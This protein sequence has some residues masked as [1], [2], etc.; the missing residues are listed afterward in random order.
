MMRL[1]P[2]LLL[3]VA[4]RGDDPDVLLVNIISTPL[5]AETSQNAEPSL[6][7]SPKAPNFLVASVW[8]PGLSYCAADSAV[9]FWTADEGQ[10]WTPACVLPKLGDTE[11]QDVTVRMSGDAKTL[12]ASWM[13]SQTTGTTTSY[14]A[15][16]YRFAPASG[17]IDALFPPSPSLVA[18]GKQ[19]YQRFDT[20]QP[21][22]ANP[23]DAIA[24]LWIGNHRADLPG[25]D[26][27][28]YVSATFA[29]NPVAGPS[30]VNC[31][32]WDRPPA[33]SVPPTPGRVSAARAAMVGGRTYV[34]IYRMAKNGYYDVVVYR[35]DGGDF[36]V[37]T[38]SVH[39]Q[40]GGGDCKKGRDALPGFRVRRCA[41][42]PYLFN[43]AG[44]PGQES[45]HVSELSIA[46]DPTNPDKVYVAW[47][48]SS[49]SSEPLKLQFARSTDGGR[50]WTLIENLSTNWYLDQSTNPALAVNSDGVVGI[51]YQQLVKIKKA[52][53][54]Q[55]Q[56]ALS[57]D[58]LAT[59]PTPI[60]LADVDASQPTMGGNP[61]L[62]DY[63][64]LHAV[65]KKFYGVFSASNYSFGKWPRLC[66]TVQ[67]HNQRPFRTSDGHPTYSN[68]KDTVAASIDPF[69]FRVTP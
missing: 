62:G 51:L 26:K 36:T 4:A 54:W 20:D 33:V 61:Y 28:L 57:K 34:V 18:A 24:G 59:A 53:H 3:T 46:V 27:C 65:G 15:L 45:R 6:A 35:S 63:L 39:K 56:F 47:A 25:A 37:I 69:F 43:G 17:T 55:T 19:L 40:S 29:E 5:V 12:Y 60:T 50:N 22:L 31:L 42:Y 13:N 21:Q 58:G 9:V 38:D 2:V 41:Q 7:I 64:E 10:N 52:Y 48:E 67:C 30:T 32:A 11:L 49:S 66:S 14:Y 44:T 23:P 1:A 16:D 68:G 8:T